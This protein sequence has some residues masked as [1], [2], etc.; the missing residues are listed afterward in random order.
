[1]IK[2]YFKIAWRNITR[3]IGYSTL[4]IL[5]LATGMAVALLIGLWVYDQYSYDKFLPE[6]ES[7]YRVQRNFD[8]NG[9]TLTFRT[10]SLR[11]AHALRNEIPEIEYVAESDWMGSHGLMVG[12]KKLY[13]DGGITGS[14][15]LKMFKYPFIYGNANTVFKDAYSI[16]LTQSTAKA[17]FG[18]ENPINRM[19]RF[20]NENNLKVTGILKDLPSNSSIDFKFIVPFSYVEQTHPEVKTDG[21]RSFGNNNSQIFVK[22]KPGIEYAQVAQKIRNI[23]HVEKG[24]INAMNSYVTLQPLERW[25]LYSNYVNGQDTAGFLE[26]VKM[27]TIIGVL[28]L[29]I[30]CINFINLTTARSE[31]RAREIGVRKAI[32]SQRKDLIIQFLSE[33]FLFTFI[34]FIF[35][36]LFVQLTL[37]AFNTL[38]K[39][40]ISI[41]LSNGYFWLLMIVCILFTSLIAGSRPAFY[42]S[43]FNPVQVLKGTIQAGASALISRKILV[44]IQFS[45]SIALIITTAIIYQQIQHAKDR[46]TGHSLDRLMSTNMNN[47]LGKNYTGLKNELIQKGIASS[48]TTASSPATN[49]WWHADIDYWPGKNAGET[50]EMGNIFVSEDYFKTVGMRIKEG[51]NFSGSNDSTSVIFN[52][53]AISR[54]R[55]KN[56]VNQKIKYGDKEYTIAGVVKDA[57]MLSPFSAADPTMFYCYPNTQDVMLYKLSANINTHDA[58]TQLTSIFNKYNPAYPYN[59]SFEDE[60]YASK[61]ELEM[62]IGKLA[63]LFAGLAIFISCLGLFGLAAYIAEQRTKEIGIRKVLGASIQQIWMLLSKDFIVLILISCLIASSVSFYFLKSWLMKYDYRISIGIGVFIL[64]G[65]IALLITIITISFQAIKAAIANPTKSLRTE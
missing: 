61:F 39:T 4:N 17:L 35:S 50:V 52:E 13:L 30:A 48:V 25:H 34:A 18:N 53:T 38:T 20:D 54:L 40:N 29:L 23:E 16:V 47:D 41:P 9:D 43:S 37:P 56:P 2:N 57:L 51:R 42:L 64:S 10:T 45:C 55:I 36:L 28:V 58:I 63:G 65:L 46:P 60:N 27:F 33:S 31:K 49:I 19:V 5:G 1:M 62:L 12:D 8:S 15:F 11:L 21:I 44:V 24:N 22:L 6:Y 7:L 3:T 32:G 59:Y 26:Y 14:D